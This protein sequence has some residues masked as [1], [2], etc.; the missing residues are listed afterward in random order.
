MIRATSLH[1]Q[2]QIKETIIVSV[3]LWKRE[4]AEVRIM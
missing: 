3:T 1:L 2:F 4:V